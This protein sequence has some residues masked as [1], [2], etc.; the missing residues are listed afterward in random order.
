MVVLN[1]R[2]FLMERTNHLSTF[3]KSNTCIHFQAFEFVHKKDYMQVCDVNNLEDMIY[4]HPNPKDI[5][6]LKEHTFHCFQ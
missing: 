4:S 3:C 5:F 1:K 2:R 6:L